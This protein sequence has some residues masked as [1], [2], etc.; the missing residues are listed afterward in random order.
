MT[1]AAGVR[2]NAA[3]RMAKT[4]SSGDRCATC[5]KRA[6]VGAST[7]APGGCC[8]PCWQEAVA[9]S[10]ESVR[11][12]AAR[13]PGAPEWAL[14]AL[15][16]DPSPLVRA[17]IALRRDLTDPL[18]DKLADPDRELDRT[19]LRR[20]ARHP[21]LGRRASDL[22]ALN[23][24]VV[25][26]QLAGNPSTPPGVLSALAYHADPAVNRAAQAR[27]IGAALDAEQRERL[28]V[29]VRSF[30]AARPARRR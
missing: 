13:R 25:Q 21:A 14:D 23:D 29:G 16:Y 30:L 6:A 19:V 18:M 7:A 12:A 28:P 10:S 20:M 5:G 27:L 17:E 4:E 3:G 2:W 9:S 26:R 24:L 8:E 22:A 15:A 11:A 1:Y